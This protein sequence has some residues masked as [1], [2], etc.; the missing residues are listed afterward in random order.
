MLQEIIPQDSLCERYSIIG[1]IS[2]MLD[3]V[4]FTNYFFHVTDSD[5]SLISPL[6][7]WTDDTKTV[8]E[9]IQELCRDS[10]MTAIFDENNVLRFYSRDYMYGR[11]SVDWTMRN[12]ESGSNLA[13]IVDMSKQD[14]PSMNQVKVLWQTPQIAVNDQN[15]GDLIWQAP[16]SYLAAFELTQA[17]PST[18]IA[19]SYM[20][21]K[22][23]AIDDY[24]KQLWEQTFSGF[25]LVNDEVIEYDALEYR[26]RLPN[27]IIW[28]TPVDITNSSDLLKYKAIADQAANGIEPTGRFR[29]KTRGALGTQAKIQTH[30]ASYKEIL[31]SWS[32]LAGVFSTGTTVPADPTASPSSSITWANTSQSLLNITN[33]DKTANSFKI[34]MKGNWP[35]ASYSSSPVYNSYGTTMFLNPADNNSSIGNSL[36]SVGGFA[37]HVNSIADT[38]YLLRIQTSIVTNASITGSKTSPKDVELYKIVNGKMSLM[39][40]TQSALRQITNITQG[41]VYKIDISVETTSNKNNI[42]ITINGDTFAVQDSTDRLAP[43]SYVGLVAIQNKSSFDYVYATKIDKA[44]YADNNGFNIY[45]GKYSEQTLNFLFGNK[46]FNDNG[47]QVSSAVEDFGPVA[48]EIRQ[49]IV[50]YSTR[51]AYP[52]MP[53]L[54]SN[55]LVNFIGSRMSPFGA[56]MYVINNSGTYI[57]ISDTQASSYFIA[58]KTLS[59]SG[60]LE[61][62]NYTV[63]EFT[64]EEPVIFESIWLQSEGDVKNLASWIKTQWAKKQSVV[65]MNI[66]GNPMISVGDIIDID[67]DYQELKAGQKFV[68]SNVVQNYTNGLETSI[69][70]R[71]L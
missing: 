67:Y 9:H 30:S 56:E 33:I 11:S 5:Q 17:I 50:R 2:R 46:I 36:N 27:S 35:V 3:N 4:G 28:Q 40:S 45:T 14:L 41:E 49:D 8:W 26:Y 32:T 20:S 24:T 57:P 55:K 43:T 19:G 29:I 58:G 65:T 21:L 39:S 15:S 52:L 1:I 42:K 47:E 38:M 54:G 10:Q 6:Y 22:A 34:A 69:V 61:Y 71:T 7:W 68:I 25:I 12:K 23:V 16:V 59:K 63:N 37:F 44:S 62:K 48:R 64:V 70:C 13:N 31:S 66:F 53:S 18:A 60:S 51:P